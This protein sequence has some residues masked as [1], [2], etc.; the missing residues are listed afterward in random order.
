MVVFIVLC[1][2]PWVSV[3]FCDVNWILLKSL[4]Y[5]SE[6]FVTVCT[7]NVSFKNK[8]HLALRWS[9]FVDLDNLEHVV[10]FS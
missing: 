9:L 2:D 8:G 4:T 7:Q 1:I 3:S 6:E 10:V 5:V